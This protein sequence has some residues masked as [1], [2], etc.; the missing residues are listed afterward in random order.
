MAPVPVNVKA[1]V[2]INNV[3]T[4][5]SAMGNEAGNIEV[6]HCLFANN[7]NPVTNY[8]WSRRPGARF[9]TMH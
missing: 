7:I 2:F 9:E 1:C 6:I 5:G 8:P 4:R 3:A